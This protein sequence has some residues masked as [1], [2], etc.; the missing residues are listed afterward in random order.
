[1][2]IPV[3]FLDLAN[4]FDK[5]PHRRL[6]DKLRKHGIG[7]KL[8]GMIC[9]WLR[10]RRQRVCIKGIKQSDWEEVWVVFL[11]VLFWVP[12]FLIF[13]NDLDDNVSG[14]VLKFADDT[15]IFG[16]VR[17]GHDNIRMQADLD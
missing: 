3:V 4:A 17:N 1:M 7:G 8:L 12:L 14:N 10:H 6:L 13:I 15:K 5:V 16:Q 11:M 9:D 2:D